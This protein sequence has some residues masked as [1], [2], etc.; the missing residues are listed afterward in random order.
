M[1]NATTMKLTTCHPRASQILWIDDL[2]Q[3]V[4]GSRRNVA[5]VFEEG[6]MTTHEELERQSLRLPF[7]NVTACTD[8][9]G[10]KRIVKR[11]RWR[12]VQVK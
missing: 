1:T 8:S 2:S 4:V 3:M 10:A 11:F 9:T 6:V 7:K 12:G 5:Q